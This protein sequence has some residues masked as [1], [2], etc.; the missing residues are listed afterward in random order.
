MEVLSVSNLKVWEREGAAST[1][2]DEIVVTPSIDNGDIVFTMQHTNA[3][4][5]HHVSAVK[6]TVTIKQAMP[7]NG[8]HTAD[9]F[10][11]TFDVF[12]H[13]VAAPSSV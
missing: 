8:M 6:F 2:N 10:V 7:L 5:V 11:E 9:L 4:I 13:T 3:D 1:T 12:L